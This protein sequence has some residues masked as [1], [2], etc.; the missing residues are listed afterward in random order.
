MVSFFAQIKK[1]ICWY[2]RAEPHRTDIHYIKWTYQWL[3]TT[4]KHFQ[5]RI[6][7]LIDRLYL[8]RFIR[9]F[10]LYKSIAALRNKTAQIYHCFR[11]VFITIAQNQ[12][13]SR[14][15]DWL[16]KPKSLMKW[17]SKWINI[18]SHMC[19]Q[20][21]LLNANALHREPLSKCWLSTACL[22]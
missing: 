2:V 16:N 10:F 11:F 21:S 15:F 6:K 4:K 1:R 12:Y 8:Q 22:K 19:Y 14:P 20:Y 18:D 5:I 17:P 3:W 13:N 9:F 7:W